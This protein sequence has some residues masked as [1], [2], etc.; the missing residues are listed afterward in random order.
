VKTGLGIVTVNDD[1]NE[2]TALLGTD[3]GRF[4]AEMMITDGWDEMV[5]NCD[6]VKFGVL[7]RLIG[8]AIGLL[9]D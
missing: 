8:T 3:D 4:S 2:T 9:H 5:T 6:G 1:G 7:I